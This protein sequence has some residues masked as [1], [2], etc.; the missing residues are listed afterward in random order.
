MFFSNQNPGLDNSNI[1][2]EQKRDIVKKLLLLDTIAGSVA[3]K[4]IEKYNNILVQQGK[5]NVI[6][7]QFEASLFIHFWKIEFESLLEKTDTGIAVFLNYMNLLD[8]SLVDCFKDG[9]IS[10]DELVTAIISKYK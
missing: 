10:L 5:G 3:K 8:E 2:E 7:M 6:V 1:T 4:E 9:L